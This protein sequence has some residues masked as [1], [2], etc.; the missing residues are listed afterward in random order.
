[1][2]GTNQL[3]ETASRAALR[4]HGQFLSHHSDSPDEND[5]RTR[6]N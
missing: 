3:A 4:D 1:L 2:D 6:P 5:V